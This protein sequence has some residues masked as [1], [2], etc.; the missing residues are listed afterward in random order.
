MREQVL[1]DFFEGRSSAEGLERDIA[2]SIKQS[3]PKTTV[4]SIEDMD[5]DFNVTSDM[6]VRLCDA[7][8]CGELR[9]EALHTIG[10]ALA[11]SDRF[12][13]DGDDE[14]LANVIADWSCPEVNYPLTFENVQRFR[15]WLAR[16]DLYPPKPPRASGKGILISTT[17][18]KST[19][20]D[21][22]GSR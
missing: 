2:G 6:A 11:A 1:R 15:A 13:W 5:T 12:Q 4:I 8:L 17:E 9:P 18:K 20:K 22:L 21:D 10:F 3:G 16:T 7:V 19:P 14:I